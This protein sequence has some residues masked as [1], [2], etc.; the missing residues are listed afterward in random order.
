MNVSRL[1]AFGSALVVLMVLAWGF[2]DQTRDP[3]ENI[4]FIQNGSAPYGDAR[5]DP[6]VDEPARL[7]AELVVDGVLY[8]MRIRREVIE[9]GSTR[10]T[11]RT[12]VDWAGA[13]EVLPQ[14]RRIRRTG[15]KRIA[16]VERV[17]TDARVDEMITS[18][19][20]VI[21][22]DISL[23]AVTDHPKIFI[24]MLDDVFDALAVLQPRMPRQPVGLGGAWVEDRDLGVGIGDLFTVPG[25]IHVTRTNEPILSNDRVPIEMKL[26]LGGPLGPVEGRL[27][28]RETPNLVGSSAQVSVGTVRGAG[29]V[30]VLPQRGIA[31]GAAR[32]QIIGSLTVVGSDGVERTPIT[33]TIK[34]KVTRD[35]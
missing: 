29:Q 12:F 19:G 34:V 7:K 25:A 17:L 23:G 5:W 13:W 15:R 26:Q 14:E 3:S 10:F 24:G 18:D 35:D 1:L 4:R 16:E 2:T 31:T 9:T 22:R 21:D 8:K 11:A 28:A 32:Y 27:T 30:R 20:E 33:M 6:K